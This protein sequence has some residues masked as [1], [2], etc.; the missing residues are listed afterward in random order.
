MYHSWQAGGF[1]SKISS[2]PSIFNTPLSSFLPTFPKHLRG[3]LQ[4]IGSSAQ[5]PG[6]DPQGSSKASKPQSG[7]VA[8][9]VL[10][11]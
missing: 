2:I 6:L 5:D 9:K 8:S 4:A 10:L 11:F 7:E 1:L 3:H